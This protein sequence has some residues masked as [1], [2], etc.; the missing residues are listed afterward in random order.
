MTT[1]VLCPCPHVPSAGKSALEERGTDGYSGKHLSGRDCFLC[2][3]SAAAG[4]RDTKGWGILSFGQGGGTECSC[5]P[6]SW[7]LTGHPACASTVTAEPMAPQLTC[8]ARV[9]EPTWDQ[10][11]MGVVP[12]RLRSWAL[13]EAWAYKL[14]MYLPHRISAGRAPESRAQPRSIEKRALCSH[15]S[16]CSQ[17]CHL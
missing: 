12:L 15:T 11:C 6:C 5:T 1:S 16:C 2:E 4:Q 10:E 7:G 13:P 8:G 9:S 17:L 3:Q 14:A